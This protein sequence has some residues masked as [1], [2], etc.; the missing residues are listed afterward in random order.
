[1]TAEGKQCLLRYLGYA[2]GPVDGIW[3]QS[4]QSALA[5]FQKA[6]GLPEGADPEAALLSA[7]AGGRFRREADFWQDIRYFQREEYR[8]PCGACGGFPAEPDEAL[9]RAQDRLREA[10][11]VPI[12]NTSGVRCQGHN[13]A[14][15]G[16]EN[17]LHLTGKAVDFYA[18]GKSA[19]ELLA[20]ARAQPE[21]VYAYAID[22]SAVH[23]N[24][25]R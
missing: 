16:V 10:L 9:V 1:M 18:P 20:L 7:V 12:Y 11:G 21:I 14:V 13:R 2:P 3:G 8:C 25:A 19:G 6:E 17:S 5:R 15:G 4:S 24:V 22:G 23:M